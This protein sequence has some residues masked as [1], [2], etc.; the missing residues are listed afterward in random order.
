V[1]YSLIRWPQLNDTQLSKKIGVKRSTIT[2]I[3]NKLEKNKLYTTVR[4]PDLERIGCELLTVRYG[5]FNP[6]ASYEAR[7]KYSSTQKFPEVF[8]KRSADRQRIAISAAKNFTE[9]KEYI[10]YSNRVYGEQ[11]FLT[12]EGIV[13]VFF[14]FKLSKIFRFFDYAPLLKQQ[15]SLD[16]KEEKAE[17]DT[18]F[19]EKEKAELTENEKQVFYAL[20]KYPQ[21][22][23]NKIAKKVSMTRQSVSTIRKKFEEEELIQDIRIPDLAAL[24]FQLLVFTHIL[25]NPKSTLSQ[26]KHCIQKILGQG[27]HIFYILGNLEFV[28][29]SVFKD[30][31]EYNRTNDEI[32]NCFKENGMLLKDPITRIFVHNDIKLNLDGR[33]STL[34]KKVLDIKTEI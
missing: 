16:S 15:F 2:A 8:F 9:V 28:L 24:E 26:R 29:I 4:V 5:S 17:L 12:D 1:L 34:V 7:E 14:P 31:P 32:V 20:I 23:D 10:D 3:R 18:E 21:L 19:M 25:V 6:L 22:N 30:Y 11:G 27:S 33:F 13:H